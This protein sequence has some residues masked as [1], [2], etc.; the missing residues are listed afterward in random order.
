MNA[1]HV[2]NQFVDVRAI[3]QYVA[4]TCNNN[5]YNERTNIA[6]YFEICEYVDVVDTTIQSLYVAHDE[7]EHN[8]RSIIDECA[9]HRGFLMIDD[10][11]AR[12]DNNV[13][14]ELNAFRRSIFESAMLTMFRC[15]HEYRM[16]E[17]HNPRVASTISESAC[18]A[19]YVY[20]D[21]FAENDDDI[22][23]ICD[24]A[25]DVKLYVQSRDAREQIDAIE[26]N[27][28]IR[29][30]DKRANISYAFCQCQHH[31]RNRLRVV[32]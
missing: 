32:K 4:R 25:D 12:Y 11:R 19:T 21:E 16:I 8:K 22:E 6:R 15:E 10:Y 9:S 5:R 3:T 24:C 26:I 17:N 28:R 13:D 29:D 14:N 20:V 2:Y 7:C 1:Q 18:F 23:S 31:M 30:F 27:N